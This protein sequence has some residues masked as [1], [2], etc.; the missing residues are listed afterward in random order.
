MLVS[1][2]E[3]NTMPANDQG[4]AAQQLRDSLTRLHDARVTSLTDSALRQRLL[5]LKRWQVQRLSNTYADLLAD[6]RYGP[7]TE[8]FRN[9]LYGPK[10]FSRRDR[11]IERI[12]STMVKIMPAGALRVVATALELEALSEELDLQLVETLGE[13]L[14]A[15]VDL[16]AEQ[17]AD[18]YRRT[19]RRLER[20]Q[21]IALIGKLGADLDRLVK[22]PFLYTSLKLMRQPAKLAGLGALQDFLEHGFNVFRHMG[23][24]GEFLEIIMRREMRILEQL[25]S[26]HASPFESESSP[27]S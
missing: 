26:R 14:T 18:A 16:T 1:P 3:M 11:D 4:S 12:Y 6:S 9:D 8:F 24:A 15:G 22:V 19:G 5:L 27:S 20:E 10:D 13:G 21:Q 17:Y 23:D 2:S 7:A 25:F